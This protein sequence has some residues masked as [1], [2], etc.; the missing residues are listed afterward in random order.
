MTGCTTQRP[1]RGPGQI[2]RED[3]LV[4][5]NITM[6]SFASRLD[7]STAQ[8]DRLLSGKM[9]IDRDLA[10]RLG[11]FLGTT[12]EF[13]QHL[14]EDADIASAIRQG[15]EPPRIA[16]NMGGNPVLARD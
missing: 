15:T 11:A 2:L 7:F 10:L 3:F 5:R 4:P 9:R 6:T 14:Q 8:M 13:W 12:P 1:P 16:Y